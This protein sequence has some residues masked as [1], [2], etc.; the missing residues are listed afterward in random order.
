MGV[1]EGPLTKPS[2]V[3]KT[4][5]MAIRCTSSLMQVI[6][7]AHPAMIVSGTIILGKMLPCNLRKNGH[8]ECL[9]MSRGPRK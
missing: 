5:L 6:K 7:V 8:F 2:T 9:L 3:N 4:L 1:P